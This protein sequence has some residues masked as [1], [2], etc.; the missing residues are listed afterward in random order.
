MDEREEIKKIIFDT[1]DELKK[2][3][4]FDVKLVKDEET[5]LFGNKSSVNSLGFVNLIVDIEQ[6]I[7]DK[8]Q[9]EITIMDENAMSIKNSPFRTIGTLIDYI[10]QLIGKK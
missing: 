2:I 5:Y 9:S 10:C 7:N 1:I 3:K 8:Y 4:I 6:K